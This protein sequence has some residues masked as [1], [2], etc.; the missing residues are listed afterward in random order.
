CRSE[1]DRVPRAVRRRIVML[2]DVDED[3]LPAIYAAADVFIAPAIGQ[4]SFGTVLLEAMA[5]GRPIVASDIEGYR[6]VVRDGVDALTVAPRDERAI[7]D[8]VG[9]I[10]DNPAL[11]RRLAL[12][13]RDRVTQFAWGVVTDA[14]E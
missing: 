6:E 5:A 1:V 13:A 9:P 10:L 11:A 7:A 14:V 8:A 12:S 4:E 2:G 3:R